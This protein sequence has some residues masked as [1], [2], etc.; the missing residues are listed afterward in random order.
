MNGTI[1]DTIRNCQK[2]LRRQNTI[3]NS[4]FILH[5][6]SLARSDRNFSKNTINNNAVSIIKTNRRNIE[7]KEGHNNSKIPLIL[8]DFNIDK[9]PPKAGND[10]DSNDNYSNKTIR[11]AKQII[12]KINK[13]IQFK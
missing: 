11:N 9:M 7:K 6:Q 2:K 4:D 1:L 13:K 12:I 10:I 8:F 3:K 5:N